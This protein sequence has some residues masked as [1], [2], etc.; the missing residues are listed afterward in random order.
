MAAYSILSLLIEL[1]E[2]IVIRVRRIDRAIIKTS[3]VDE[4][5][6]I[7]RWD[8]YQPAQKCFRIPLQHLAVS[9]LLFNWASIHFLRY[10]DVRAIRLVKSRT[11]IVSES[12]RMYSV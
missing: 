9:S 6:I 12:N 11:E 5:K 4:F 1:G 10:R 8:Q 2:I 3:S 7:S